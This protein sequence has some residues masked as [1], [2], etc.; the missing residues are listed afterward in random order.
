[1]VVS[2]SPELVL[3]PE[4]LYLGALPESLV[5]GSLHEACVEGWLASALPLSVLI[6]GRVL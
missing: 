6:S 2:V 3:V 4:N 1:M 5:M